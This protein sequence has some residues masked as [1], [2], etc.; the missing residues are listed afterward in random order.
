MEC[1]DHLWII[2]VADLFWIFIVK[3]LTFTHSAQSVIHFSILEAEQF[4]TDKGMTVK[5]VH[6]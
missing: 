2:C 4:M 6:G 5:R 3:I 1:I